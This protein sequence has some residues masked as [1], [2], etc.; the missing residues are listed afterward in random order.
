MERFEEKLQEYASLLINVGL[1]VKKGQKLVIHAPV[2][3]VTFARMCAKAGYAAGAEEVIVS[4]SDEVLSRMKYLEAD[5]SVFDSVAEWVKHLYNDYAEMGAAML[6]IAASDPE[7]LKG[8]DPDRIQRSSRVSGEA[9]ATFRRLEMSN[10]FPWCIASIPI[11]SWAAKVFPDDAGEVAMEKL[12]DAIF[13][14]VRVQGDGGAV[15]RW[16][17]HLA[18]LKARTD[19]LNA[20]RLSKLHY[21]NSIGTD[22]W[23][24]LPPD[25]IWMSGEDRTP[26]GQRFVANMPTEEI[27]TAPLKEG[28]NGKVV[29][30]LPLSHGGS[31]ITDFSMELEKGKI[32]AVRAKTGEE[33][34]KNAVTV[35]EGASYFGE[36]ALIPYDSPIRNRG[37]LYYETLFDENASCHFAF[38][39]AYPCIE[40]G[41]EMEPEELIAHG[42]NQSITHV[43]FMVGTEDLSIVGYRADGEAVTV[44]ENGNFVF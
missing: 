23:V 19:K 40:G 17:D 9:L 21:T 12:W 4:Y 13:A 41:M 33:Q 36:V 1:A 34:L 29:A 31:L 6:F 37:I 7:N 8:V 20:L 44:F 5:S 38:G 2:D 39:E 16:R 11:P 28:V 27:F 14:A 32:V 35:D 10:G 24:E 26:T 30:A 15:A 18:H 25:H 43:D 42:L 22:L 3:S